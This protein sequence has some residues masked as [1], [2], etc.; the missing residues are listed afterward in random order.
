MSTTNGKSA[1]DSTL[2]HRG[3]APRFQVSDLPETVPAPALRSHAHGDGHEDLLAA[4]VDSKVY[5]EYEHAFTET[6]GMPMALRPVES[7]QLPLHGK[8]HEA[9]YCAL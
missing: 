3:L 1:A 8:R 5:R 9:P 2:S 7:W 6:T 4:M